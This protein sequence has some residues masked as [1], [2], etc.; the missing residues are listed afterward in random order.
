[1]AKAKP[2]NTIT[3][4]GAGNLA[5]ALAQL[6]PSAGYKVSEIVTRSSSQRARSLGRKTGALV[7]TIGRA[8]WSGN[9]VWLAVSDSA[10]HDVGEA[11][12]PAANWRGKVVLHSSGALSSKVLLPLRRRG[13]H[14][15]SVHP[16][17]TFVVGAS[18]KMAEVFWAVEGDRVA[19]AAAGRIVRSLQGQ[20]LKIDSKR[21]SLYHTFGAFLSPLL[22]VHFVTAAKVALKIGIPRQK[23]AP[24]MKPIVERTLRNFLANVDQPRGAGNA[25]SGPLVRG[26]M[27]TIRSH[28]QSLRQVPDARKLYVALLESAL[29]SDLPLKNRSAIKKLLSGSR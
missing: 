21:K 6:L 10:I 14:V 2:S 18:P 12:A 9:I 28:L 15:A 22:V 27:G 16:M 1:M 25:F 4:V 11:I 7:T 13:A 20:V 17:M 29:E 26:D 8:R 5:H 24:L 23:L 3:L 19:V